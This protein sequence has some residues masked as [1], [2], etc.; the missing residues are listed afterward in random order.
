MPPTRLVSPDIGAPV[1]DARGEAKRAMVV[2]IWQSFRR[3]PAWVQIWVA[4]I[5]VPVNLMALC[6][7][8]E[9]QG[10]WVAALAVAGMA[11]NLVIMMRDHGFSRAMALSHLLFWIPLVILLTGLLTGG[12]ELAGSYRQYLILLLVVD[13]VSLGFDCR[14][15]WRW[16]NGDRGAA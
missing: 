6:Y 8:D 2:E 11:P 15:A 10:A 16:W 4:L 3:L 12:A 1:L 13:L 9:P 7:V 5:L 14:D